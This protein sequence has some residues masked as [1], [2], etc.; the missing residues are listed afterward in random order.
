MT[1]QLNKE[2]I[3]KLIKEVWDAV[4]Q[5]SDTDPDKIFFV[6]QATVVERRVRRELFRQETQKNM[7]AD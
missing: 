2:K 3:E 4:N 5:I 1:L 7:F 6:H